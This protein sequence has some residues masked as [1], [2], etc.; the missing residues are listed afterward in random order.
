MQKLS[1]DPRKRSILDD[2][3]TLWPG[4]PYLGLGVWLAWALLAYSG[5]IWLSDTEMDGSNL[6]AMYLVSTSGVTIAL[7]LSPLFYQFYKTIL[8]SRLCLLGA[9]ALTTL[10]ASGIILS[11]PYYLNFV[12]L[13]Y[14]G[15]FLTGLGTGVIALKCGELYGELT[16][17]K[18]LIYAAL[19]QIVIVI[20]FF[21][22]LG[23]ENYQPVAGGPSLGGI[24]A[25]LA[26]P[27]VAALLVSMKP[28]RQVSKTAEDAI[29]YQHDFK[30]LSPVFWKFLFAVFILTLATSL[31]SGLNISLAP[32]SATLRS[33]NTLMLLRILVAAVFFIL[34]L[35]A[36]RRIDFGK[37]YLFIMVAVAIAVVVLPLIAGFGG[38]LGLTIGFFFNTFDFIVWC[39]LA[40]IAFQK[41]I[42]PIIVF[43][44]GRGIFMAGSAIGWYLGMNLMPA[45]E[46][47]SMDTIV[48]VALAVLI[49]VC[50]TLVFS[51]RDFDR[52]FTPIAEVEL[53]LD[54]ISLNTSSGTNGAE[55]QRN[56]ERPFAKACKRVGTDAQ[57]SAREQDVFEL[58]ALGRGSENIATKLSISLNTA[59]THTHNVYAKLNVHSR[60]GLIDL[61]EKERQKQESN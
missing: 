59:R 29:A 58:L 44:F 6:A 53:I 43:G 50:V 38:P 37:L 20:L 2:L 36:F 56:P 31:V 18:A 8:S 28:A 48:Y 23:N 47:S 35:R 40:S 33:S 27:M 30:L 1:E 25:L 61:V 32:P 17:Q 5:T 24:I 52:L 22:T 39:L 16:P 14:I 41:K 7:L 45:F 49:L 57:L 4:L 21:F 54:D 13:F 42:S 9:G 10:G 55:D 15:A 34:A 60:Q 19:S 46:A 3:V 26:L 12:P 11:G 51:E